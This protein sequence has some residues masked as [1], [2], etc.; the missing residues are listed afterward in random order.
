MDDFIVQPHQNDPV[1]AFDLLFKLY[2]V[3]N[4]KYPAPLAKFYEFMQHFIYE[5]IAKNVR[6]IVTELHVILDQFK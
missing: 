6:G 4:V 5:L 1:T 3:L 2:Y